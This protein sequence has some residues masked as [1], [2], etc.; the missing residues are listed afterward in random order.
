MEA[1]MKRV[2]KKKYQRKV[3]ILSL[4]AIPLAIYFFST[5]SYWFQILQYRKETASLKETLNQ[6]LEEES[7][8]KS[9][10]T[11]LQDPEYIARYARE[12]YLYSKDG[13]IIFRIED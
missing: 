6:K 10:I 1:S 12:K 2:S 7:E 3:I 13:E 11:K 4:I 9:Q 5:F 8:L